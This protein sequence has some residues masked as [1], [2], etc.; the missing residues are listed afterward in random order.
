M[1]GRLSLIAAALL[2]ASGCATIV[3]GTTQD[4]TFHSNPEGASVSVDGKTLGRTPLTYPLK[5]DAYDSV[6][7]EKD[8][9]ETLMMPL[10]HPISGWF[11][12]N[13]IFGGLVGSTTDGISGAA[14]EYS[15]GQFMVTLQP[16]HASELESEPLKSDRQ[17]AREYIVIAYDNIIPQLTTG[18][19]DY[20]RSLLG[21]LKIPAADQAE[22]IKKLRALS[23]VYTEIP[24]FADRAIELYLKT[25]PAEEALPA[26]APKADWETV[27]SGSPKDQYECLVASS[28][29]EAERDIEMMSPKQGGALSEYILA[30]KGRKSGLSWT[31]EIAPDLPSNDRTFIVWYLHQHT[32]Y[33]AR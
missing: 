2:G 5:K 6:T 19:G 29:G 11:W 8:G 24:D 30:E 22:A 25:A 13:I 9:Y 12:G 1:T 3:K 28:R 31:F 26:P 4:M 33:K 14:L 32:D 7:F 18:Q 17:K 21:V 23:E 27:K 10:G 20:V 15:P 16:L